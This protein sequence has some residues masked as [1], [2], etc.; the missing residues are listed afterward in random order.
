MGS[1]RVMQI[2]DWLNAN[3][4]AVMGIATVV[5]VIIIGYYAYLTWQLLKI[6]DMPEIV[7]SLRPHEAYINLVALC[8][9]NIGTRAARD[10]QFLTNPASLPGVDIPLEEISFIKNG[11]AYFEP[12]RKI[13]HFLVNVI[14]DG[15]LE[16]LKHTPF[17]V[18]VTYKDSVKRHHERSFALD[19]GEDEGLARIGKPPLFEIAETTKQIQKDLHNFTTGTGFH[20]PIVLTE[21]LTQH[22][23]GKRVSSLEIR[24]EHLPQEA[25]E[26]ILNQIAVAVDKKELE[27][28]E[29]RWQQQAAADT[30]KDEQ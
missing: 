5:L 16:E 26:E 7:V 27:I 19:F 30:K 4:G 2:I 20:K 13:E 25:Q 22:R 17:E 12:G 3:S 11:I 21:S 28:R 6:N 18:T 29:R 8:V 23:R 10:V 9:E 14:A 1:K 24:I 15:K